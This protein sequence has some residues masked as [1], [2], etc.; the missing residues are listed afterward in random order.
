MTLL[1]ASAL[2]LTSTLSPAA[3]LTAID[4]TIAREPA[5]AGKSPRYALLVLGQH[6]DQSPLRDRQSQLILVGACDEAGH[7]I[8]GDRQ[9][10]GQIV[11]QPQGSLR[12]RAAGGLPSGPFHVEKAMDSM[13]FTIAECRSG[14]C[15]G[16]SLLK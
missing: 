1:V 4:R 14:Q 10:V 9:A 11:L 12:R 7:G 8:A 13:G 6:G 2:I 16:H 3:D 5:Y 15:R